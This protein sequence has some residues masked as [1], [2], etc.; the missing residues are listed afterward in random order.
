MNQVKLL[1]VCNINR[2][3]IKIFKANILIFIEKNKFNRNFPSLKGF[4]PPIYKNII[5]SRSQHPF[6][7]GNQKFSSMVEPL[8]EKKLKITNCEE[9]ESLLAELGIEFYV[10]LLNPLI[11]RLFTMKQCSR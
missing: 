2:R 3:I 4:F 7:L 10:R 9:T 5:F 6:L 11:F 1:D 8:E